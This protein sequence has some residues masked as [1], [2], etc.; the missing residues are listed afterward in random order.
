MNVTNIQSIIAPILTP[1]APA[2]LFGNNL[3]NGMV[4]DG[5]NHSLAITAAVLGTAG[6]ELSGALACGMAVMAYHR[7][8]YKIMWISIFAA[9]VYALFVVVGILQAKNTA[10]FAGA[11]AISLIAYLMQGVWQSYNDKLRTEQVE[12]NLQ[13]S[14]MEAERKLTNAQTRQVKAGAT[15]QRP[16]ASG[17]A[18]HAGQ[19]TAN[20]ELI[21]SIQAFWEAN[22]NASLRQCASAC[23]CSPMTASKYK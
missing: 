2:V 1:I 12:T 7:R 13:I 23:K 9:L 5:V 17:H 15:V 16:T 22:P 20:E 11:V 3:Y 21:K 10:T 18:G 4:A 14:L 19:F 6:T 8:D